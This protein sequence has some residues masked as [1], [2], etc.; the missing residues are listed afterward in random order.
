MVQPTM[1]LSNHRLY[2]A[3]SKCKKN[4]KNV[5]GEGDDQPWDFGGDPISDKPWQTYVWHTAGRLE[6][7]CHQMSPRSAEIICAILRSLR[8]LSAPVPSSR[9]SPCSRTPTRPEEHGTSYNSYAKR[10]PPKSG[11]EIH[12]VIWT[13]LNHD[14]LW[15][16]TITMDHGLLT[17][18]FD[19]DTL[20]SIQKLLA[21]WLEMTG[22]SRRHVQ[23]K[24]SIAIKSQGKIPM[25]VNHCGLINVVYI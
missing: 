15:G 10:Y 11:F 16:W 25:I 18:F 23:E 20:C 9:E 4:H 13:Y 14:T 17:R 8:A 6:G 22:A 1:G 7:P 21:R 2:P 19:H 24:M 12:M 3:Q 5:H